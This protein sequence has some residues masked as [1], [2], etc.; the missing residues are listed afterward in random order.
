M[1]WMFNKCSNLRTIYVGSGWNTASVTASSNMFTNCTSL[2]GGQGTTYNSS[3]PKDKT[4]AHIDGGPSNPGYFTDKNASLRG[5]VNGDGEVSIDDVTALIDY[6]LTG[7]ATGVNLNG[8]DCD[9]SGDVSI[10]DVT[11]LIDYLLTGNW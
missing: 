1:G 6:L 2:V 7:V 3:N 9:Q 5:D 10:D 11:A 4:Y 8:A